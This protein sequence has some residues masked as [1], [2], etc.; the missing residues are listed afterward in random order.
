MNLVTAAAELGQGLKIVREVW[1]ETR[2]GWQDIVAEEFD[3][4][5]WTPLA[6]QVVS[7]AEAMDR[8]AP[9]LARM[10]RECS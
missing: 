7:A 9:V 5:H 2:T 8:L 6:D 10:Y 3:K 1:E 4:R